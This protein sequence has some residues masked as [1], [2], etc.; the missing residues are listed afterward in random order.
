MNIIFSNTI[1]VKVF[2]TYGSLYDKKECS[3]ENT[4]IIDILLRYITLVLLDG[5]I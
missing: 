2:L 4:F 3:D 1:Y 5:I